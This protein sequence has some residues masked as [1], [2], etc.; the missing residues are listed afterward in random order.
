MSPLNSM[1]EDMVGRFQV[2][3]S[4]TFWFTEKLWIILYVFMAVSFKIPCIF[5]QAYEPNKD[6]NF[7]ILALLYYSH[8]MS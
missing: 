3:T 2:T 1:S 7:K 5:L 6:N 4:E 8:R